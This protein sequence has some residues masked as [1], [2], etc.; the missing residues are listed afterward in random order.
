MTSFLKPAAAGLLLCALMS[1]GA[2]AESHSDMS[3]T[4]SK[5]GPDD[6]IG[7]ANLLTPELAKMAAGLVTEGYR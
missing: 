1:G 3:W 2:L 4:E 5:Y 6:E 7:A